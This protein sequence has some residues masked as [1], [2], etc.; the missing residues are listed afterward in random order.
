VETSKDNLKGRLKRR[1]R[2][3]LHDLARTGGL[4][5]EQ[6]VVNTGEA[7]TEMAGTP[8][9]IQSLQERLAQLKQREREL[10]D[11]FTQ[12]QAS[13]ERAKELE[14]MLVAIAD[15]IAALESSLSATRP[16]LRNTKN[17]GCP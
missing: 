2:D 11:Q 6:D 13:V 12:S 1:T 4:A 7:N 9:E 16:A 5:L 3:K 8:N 15:E 10:R 17:P 14:L